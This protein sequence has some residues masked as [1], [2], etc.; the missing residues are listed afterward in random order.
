MSVKIIKVGSMVNRAIVLAIVIILLAI[1]VFFTKSF[2]G[3]SISTQAQNKETAEFAIMLAPGD[4][5]TRYVL[6][7]IGEKS[8]VPEELAESESSFEEATALSPND[9]RLWLALGKVRE[10]NGNAESAELAFQQA[11][12]LAPNYSQV[13]WVYGNVLLRQGKNKEAFKEIRS[14]VEGDSKFAGP[15]ANAMWQIYEGD[16]QK[17]RETIGDSKHVNTALAVFL[18]TQDKTNDAIDIWNTLSPEEKKTDFK[19]K[20]EEIY[21]QL[22]SNKKFRKALKV[23]SDISS[24]DDQKFKLSEVDNGGFESK[25]KTKK[26]D[27]FEW[28]IVAGAKPKISI[29]SNQK[30]TGRQSLVIIFKSTK[31]SDF[32]TISQTIAVDSG[33]DYEFSFYHKSELDTSSTVKWEVIDTA[34]NKVLASTDPVSSNSDW[35]RLAVTFAVPEDTEGVK[36]RM[37]RFGCKSQLCPISGKVWFDDFKIE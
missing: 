23:K 27:V 11:K 1:L 13:Q 14:A 2:L 34:S 8:F 33:R 22:I 9:Y 6:G 16:I 37:V 21:T 29:S 5:Q 26:A 35:E 12:K 30:K 36:I 20:G 15:A 18:I 31:T 4:S 24:E 28:N 19:E 25:V 10:R 3:N 17:I 7:I 32:R